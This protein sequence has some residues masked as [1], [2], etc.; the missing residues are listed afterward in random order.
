MKKVSTHRKI[1]RLVLE[2][3]ARK[4]RP[5]QAYIEAMKYVESGELHGIIIVDSRAMPLIDSS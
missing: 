3:E 4:T 2:F 1:H 5:G